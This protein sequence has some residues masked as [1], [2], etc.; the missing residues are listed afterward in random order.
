M[1]ALGHPLVSLRGGQHA[2]IARVV[3]ADAAAVVAYFDWVSNETDFAAFGPGGYGR[4]VADEVLHIRSLSDPNKGLM[5]KATIASELAGIVAINRFGAPR[6]RHGGVLGISVLQ[7]YWG[8]GLGRAL[9][10]AAIVEARHIGL[11]R[12][13]LR[14]RHDNQRAVALYEALGFQLEGRLRGAFR[15]DQAE[16]DDL[17]MALR[18]HADR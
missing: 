12:I 2:A 1:T 5:L 7:K 13:E 11:T 8:I 14:A 16:H 3:E 4:T 6:V 18:L 9:C 15:V 10:E 17:L